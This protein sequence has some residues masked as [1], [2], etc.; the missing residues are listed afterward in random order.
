MPPMVSNEEV[1]HRLDAWSEW[2]SRLQ[3]CGLGYPR[4]S[5]LYRMARYGPDAAFTQG[6]GE[7]PDDIPNEIWQTDLAIAHLPVQVKRVIMAKW[8]G[9]DEKG[10]PLKSHTDQGRAEELRLTYR[11]WRLMISEGIARLSAYLSALC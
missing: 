1:R 3:D 11:T 2:Y 10:K 6:T 9:V 7:K 8:R 5:V 4:E